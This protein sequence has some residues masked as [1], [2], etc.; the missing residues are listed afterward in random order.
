M[1]ISQLKK[2]YEQI[3]DAK[4]GTQAKYFTDEQIMDLE[5]KETAIL[6]ELQTRKYLDDQS[7]QDYL[8]WWKKMN[9]KKRSR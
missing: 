5:R 7:K 9:Y 8:D 1:G 4:W 2:T 6:R 3:Y